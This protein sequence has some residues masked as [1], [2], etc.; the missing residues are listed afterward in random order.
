MQI[1]TDISTPGQRRDLMGKVKRTTSHPVFEQQIEERHAFQPLISTEQNNPSSLC[2]SLNGI[3]TIR[4]HTPIPHET[5]L[6]FP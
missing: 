2:C 4:N 3:T 1:P 6:K 5:Y